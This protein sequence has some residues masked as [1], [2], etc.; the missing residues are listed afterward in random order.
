MRNARN[1]IAELTKQPRG[2]V[3][4]WRSGAVVAC[5][6]HA[7]E[8]VGSNPTSAILRGSLMDRTLKRCHAPCDTDSN[9]SFFDGNEE[10]GV[11]FPP[12]QL[13][14]ISVLKPNMER[15]RNGRRGSY[16]QYVMFVALTAIYYSL[17]PASLMVQIHPSPFKAMAQMSLQIKKMRQL[18]E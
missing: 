11:R 4:L 15:W 3:A 8:V 10:M 5:R 16:V 6:V 2:E 14:R 18:H 13:I 1:D 12:T 7:P 9:N 17:G